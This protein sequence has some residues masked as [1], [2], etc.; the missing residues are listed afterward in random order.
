MTA[1]ASPAPVPPAGELPPVGPLAA[2][3]GPPPDRLPH[4]LT[5]PREYLGAFYDATGARVL[6]STPAPA[7]GVVLFGRTW[8]QA[9]LAERLFWAVTALGCAVVLGLAMWLEA[10]RRGVGTHEQLGLPPCGFVEMFDI[11]C[12]SCGFTTTYTLAAHGRFIDAAVNQPFGLFLF[13]L[14]ALAVPAGVIA[15]ARN[16]SLLDATVRW[17]WNRIMLGLLVGWLACW[18]YKWLTW[19]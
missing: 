8:P 4:G 13:V 11:P 18:G 3:A 6:S 1:E 9:R 14:T 12:P 17:P 15:A 19:H 5:G 2:F 16:V 7:A 10:D